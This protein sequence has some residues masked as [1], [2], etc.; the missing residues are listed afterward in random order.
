MNQLEPAD[1]RTDLGR[2]RDNT[3]HALYHLI[4]LRIL[5]WPYASAHTTVHGGSV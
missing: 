1:T 3:H 5:W 2:A 4:P